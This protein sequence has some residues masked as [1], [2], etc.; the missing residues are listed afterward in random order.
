MNPFLEQA[1][2][3]ED[4]HQDFL[5]R[6]REA[7]MAQVG[8]NYLV[9]V[10][11]R[12]YLHE[13]SAQERRYFGRADVAVSSRTT[14]LA[15]RPASCLAAPVQ[16]QLP[17]V[18]VERQTFLEIRDR[19]DRRVIT[20]VEL[21]SPTNKTPGADRDAY[22]SKR[23]E[24]LAGHTHLVELDLRRGGE[25]PYPPELP[26]CDYYAMVSRYEDR[27]TIGF[28]PIALRERL[29]VV[30]VPLAAPDTHVEL[31]LQTVL[32]RVYDAAGFGRYIYDETPEPPLSAADAAWAATF[33]SSRP[34]APY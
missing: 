10:E 20:V 16:L 21:L 13:L 31:D 34:L 23:G 17:A 15:S 4:F 25:R 9:K 29:P 8:S 1:D 24:V 19:R 27:P 18:D 32:D 11:A 22:L 14:A 7:L 3:W 5:I 33:S 26:P 30:P 28:W 6:A 2:A 12:L